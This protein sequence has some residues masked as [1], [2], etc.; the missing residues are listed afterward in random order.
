LGGRD[1]A[2]VAGDGCT[3]KVG[4]GSTNVGVARLDAVTSTAASIGFK[5]RFRLRPMSRSGIPLVGN[6]AARGQNRQAAN[7]T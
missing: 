1:L 7:L 4:V 6:Q 2:I 5:V 3:M